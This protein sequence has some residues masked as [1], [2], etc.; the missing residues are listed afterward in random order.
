MPQAIAFFRTVVTLMA[1]SNWASADPRETSLVTHSSAVAGST[2]ATSINSVL[3]QN[4]A[5]T[6]VT[7]DCVQE[8]IP[9]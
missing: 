9:G 1:V 6:E 8:R 3:A 2:R 4:C 7:F 5:L